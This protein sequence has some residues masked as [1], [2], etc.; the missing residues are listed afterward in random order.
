V[1]QKGTLV[2]T[3]PDK[4]NCG[5]RKAIS[6]C[7]ILKEVPFTHVVS[8]INEASLNSTLKEYETLDVQAFLLSIVVIEILTGNHY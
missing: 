1:N 7:R 4:T 5:Q 6:I 2:E 8:T 3:F